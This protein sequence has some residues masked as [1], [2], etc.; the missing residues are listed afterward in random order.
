MDL[1]DPNE[2]E[3]ADAFRFDL[4]GLIKTIFL[5]YIAASLSDPLVFLG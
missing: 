2:E 4:I 1:F 3:I 5:K